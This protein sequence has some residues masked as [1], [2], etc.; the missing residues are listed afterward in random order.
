MNQKQL[1]YSLSMTF[2]M[3]KRILHNSATLLLTGGG[4]VD[5]AA[6]K[7]TKQKGGTAVEN[8]VPPHG[9]NCGGSAVN[10]Q[11]DKLIHNILNISLEN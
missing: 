8:L 11:F 3:M 5:I 2:Y 10:D 9:G 6:Q 4:T 1:H 7:V